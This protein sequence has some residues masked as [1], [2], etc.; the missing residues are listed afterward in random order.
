MLKN[1]NATPSQS[2]TFASPTS[3][4]TNQSTKACKRVC[5]PNAEKKKLKISFP[6]KNFKNANSQSDTKT[7]GQLVAKLN[8]DRGCETRTTR[9]PGHNSTYTQAGVLR[10]VGQKSAKFEVQFLVGSLVLKSLP[11]CSR[12]PLCIK[13]AFNQDSKSGNKIFPAISSQQKFLCS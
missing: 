5:L 13:K 2:Y 7:F 4:H 12:K 9:T 1:E 6:S 8:I 3:R 11:A 10:F